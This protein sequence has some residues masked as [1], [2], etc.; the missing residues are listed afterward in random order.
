MKGRFI[1]ILFLLVIS[2]TGCRA[3]GTN[4][5]AVDPLRTVA[6]VPMKCLVCQ[7]KG[8][9][10]LSVRFDEIILSNGQVTVIGSFSGFPE[11]KMT[12]NHSFFGVALSCAIF[13]SQGSDKPF[14][15]VGDNEFVMPTCLPSNMIYAESKLF[16]GGEPSVRFSHSYKGFPSDTETRSD[17]SKMNMISRIQGTMNVRYLIKSLIMVRFDDTDYEY[18]N[19]DYSLINIKGEGSCLLRVLEK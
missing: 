14:R 13:Y 10:E 12:I 11:R 15:L 4:I 9:P 5:H 6:G 16:A 2:L 7:K 1:L 3:K 18:P 17:K 19:K 8:L